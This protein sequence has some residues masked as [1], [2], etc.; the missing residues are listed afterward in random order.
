MIVVAFVIDNGTM[1]ATGT[2]LPFC[3]HECRDKHIDNYKESLYSKGEDGANSE[4]QFEGAQ[5]EACGKP[6]TLVDI[7]MPAVGRFNQRQTDEV[8]YQANQFVANIPDEAIRT[9]V[10]DQTPVEIAAMVGLICS[11]L[12]QRILSAGET[13]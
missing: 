6:L 7:P 11:K 10:F 5:C 12:S 13:K 2:V 3:S 1:E 9:L 4:E 8:F